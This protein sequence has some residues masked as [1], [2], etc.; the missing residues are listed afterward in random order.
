[1]FLRSLKFKFPLA[2]I[3]GVHA[4]N[5]SPARQSPQKIQELEGPAGKMPW[6]LPLAAA[7]P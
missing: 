6:A 4:K 5:C 3:C 1:M 7:M 2:Y